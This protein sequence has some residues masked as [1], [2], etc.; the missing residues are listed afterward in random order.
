MAHSHELLRLIKAVRDGDET[1]FRELY[2]A[3]QSRLFNTAL[4][5]VRSREDAEEITQDV[6]IEVYRSAGAFKEE[7]GVMTWLY[8]IVVNK[9]LDFIKH[10]KRQ[11]RF[12]FLISL[13]DTG[14]GE[15]VY[16][17]VDF[18][19]PGVTLENKENAVILFRAVD[20][21]APKQKTAYILTR[22]EGLSNIEAAEIMGTSVGA[23]ESL[24]QRANENLK[25]QLGEWYKSTKP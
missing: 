2:E 1:A 11:K 14:T 6:F 5:Y 19:H 17:P 25:K 18:V 13:F 24:V 23:V 15:V 3:T 20:E 22:V 7:S 10:K 8:R 16:E 21:L 12:S 9:S 4:T